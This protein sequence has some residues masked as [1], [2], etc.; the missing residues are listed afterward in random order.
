MEA[1]LKRCLSLAEA[2]LIE[3]SGLIRSGEELS[4]FEISELL[5]AEELQ[6][7]VLARTLNLLKGRSG[8][9]DYL[10]ELPDEIERLIVDPYPGDEPDNDD[11]CDILMKTPIG[12]MQS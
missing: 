6:A 9:D 3:L 7:N 10:S 11:E 12:G 4:E 8:N 2:N 1:R 5:L